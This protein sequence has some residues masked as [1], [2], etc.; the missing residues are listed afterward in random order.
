MNF[1]LSNWFSFLGFSKNLKFYTFPPIEEWRYLWFH[2][3]CRPQQRQNKLK[4]VLSNLTGVSL[5]FKYFLG[6]SFSKGC[7]CV[8]PPG[9]A[10]SHSIHLAV[11]PPT[12]PTKKH[13]VFGSFQPFYLLVRSAH[14]GKVWEYFFSSWKKKKKV[15]SIL[16]WSVL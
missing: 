2:L 1:P 16:F 11:R 4:K 7:S 5:A 12:K 9:E 13:L 15:F 8:W 6:G 10:P 3:R 14:W